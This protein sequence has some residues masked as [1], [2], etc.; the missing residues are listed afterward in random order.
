[1]WRRVARRE[2]TSADKE[3]IVSE[4]PSPETPAKVLENWMKRFW[5]DVRE[6]AKLQ[7]PLL[8][9]IAV[10]IVVILL[11]QILY[12]GLISQVYN[13][14]AAGTFGDA[15]GFLTALF[16]GVGFVA[17][18]AI[19]FTQLEDIKRREKERSEK[20]R[21][22]RRVTTMSM[23]YDLENEFGSERM[24]MQRH[25]A[26]A[27]FLDAESGERRKPTPK[28]ELAIRDTLYFL[29]RVAHFTNEDLVDDDLVL[30]IFGSRLLVYWKYAKDYILSLGEIS[31][32]SLRLAELRWLC[33]NKKGIRAWLRWM[34]DEEMKRQMEDVPDDQRI[35]IRRQTN[36]QYEADI[37]H[38][39]DEAELHKRLKREYLRSA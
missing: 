30:S 24:R 17:T 4:N 32:S 11:L 3:V 20:E 1:V 39:F 22:Q 27:F 12:F 23:V 15:F 14:K 10:A 35:V 16:T 19:I 28:Q 18:A 31:S 33:E 34:N 9:A 5:G 21:L 25:I 7:T 6:K 38:W 37:A 2:Y 13:V 8:E 26:C 29:E 36:A